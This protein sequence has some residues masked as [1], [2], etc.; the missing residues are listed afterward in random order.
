MSSPAAKRRAI[1]R[2]VVRL[3]V[4][5][6]DLRASM[7]AGSSAIGNS[8]EYSDIDL[9]NYYDE[10]PDADAF[11][12]LIVSLGAERIG[13]V[14]R[15]N[16]EGFGINYRLGGIEVQTGGQLTSSLNRR[17]D[18]IAAGD[19]DWVTT[20]IA[21]GLLE[22][23][24]LHGEGLVRGW[25]ERAAYPESLRRRQ[26]EAHLGFF[27]IWTV[28]AHLAVRDAEPFRRQMLLDGAFRVLAVLSAI[29]RLYFTTFQ[30][31]RTRAHADRMAMKP[32]RLAERLDSI[33]NAAP[34]AAAEELAALVVETKGIVKSEFPDVEIN[35]TWRPV[36]LNELN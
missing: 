5:A 29:N 12:R 19:V 21:M 6:T 36:P 32:E 16:P 1:A 8:D 7:L 25:K 27:P 18:Q 20:K 22:G 11:D 17:L 33:A 2:R 13:D 10:L 34:S 31:K 9:L 28:D 24:P 3:L 4:A 23:L 15:P 35:V 26:V 14:I 30:F